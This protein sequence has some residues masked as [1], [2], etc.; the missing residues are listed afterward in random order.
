MP[1][2]KE[3]ASKS[4]CNTRESGLPSGATNVVGVKCRAPFTDSALKTIRCRI[5]EPTSKI[6]VIITTIVKTSRSDRR[7]VRA[8]I[9]RSPPKVDHPAAFRPLFYQFLPAPDR[10]HQSDH[11]H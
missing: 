1:A 9:K 8:F 6:T 2:P 5:A 11:R 10:L 4:D 7:G 3:E